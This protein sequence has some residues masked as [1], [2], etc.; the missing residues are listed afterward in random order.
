[1]CLIRTWAINLEKTNN[2]NL[3]NNDDIKRKSLRLKAAVLAPDIR[4]FGAIQNTT[5]NNKIKHKKERTVC[6]L[7]V[8]IFIF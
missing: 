3:K 8:R 4:F 7:F 1:M 6:L 2:Y 5:C